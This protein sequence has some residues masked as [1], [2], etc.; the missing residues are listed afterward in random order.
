MYKGAVTARNLRKVNSI[1][2]FEAIVYSNSNKEALISKSSHHF[3]EREH[4]FANCK[5]HWDRQNKHIPGMHNYEE[6]KSI[7]THQNPDE[8]L[9]KYAGLGKKER[10]T[11]GNPGYKETVDFGEII[12]NWKSEDGILQI[13]TTRGTIHHSKNGSHIVPAKPI[14]PFTVMK[15]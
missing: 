3:H 5:I 12:G 13:P 11:I 4:F 1:H 9:K 6:G 8:L 10:G 2:N 7:I 14:E 15:P